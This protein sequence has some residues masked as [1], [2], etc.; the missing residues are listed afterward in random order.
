MRQEK[1]MGA[2]LDGKIRAKKLSNYRVFK[3]LGYSQAKF[4]N[5]LYKAQ[6][7]PLNEFARICEYLGV[8]YQEFLEFIPKY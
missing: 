5:W 6:K 1:E 7:V 8:D 2:F 4:E 3:D